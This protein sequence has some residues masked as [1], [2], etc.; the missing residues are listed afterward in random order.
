MRGEEYGLCRSLGNHMETQKGLP[1][2]FNIGPAS[3]IA[4]GIIIGGY[5]PR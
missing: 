2:G 5:Y 1:Q 4:V 3:S